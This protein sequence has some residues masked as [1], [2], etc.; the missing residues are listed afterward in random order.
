MD[1]DYK[2]HRRFVVSSIWFI[3]ALTFFVSVGL[4]MILL[5]NNV[6]GVVNPVL[7]PSYGLLLLM[8]IVYILQFSLA[9]IALKT[10]F[11]LLNNYIKYAVVL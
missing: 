3:L 4:S 6:A 8:M 11:K 2:Q 7:T 10:R 1:V 9:C 5:V